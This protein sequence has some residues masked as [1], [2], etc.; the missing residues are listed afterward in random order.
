LSRIELCYISCF[1]RKFQCLQHCQ[2][3]DAGTRYRYL[4]SLLSRVE[5]VPVI[6]QIQFY[7]T[8]ETITLIKV[9]RIAGTGTCTTGST[10]TF[11]KYKLQYYGIPVYTGMVRVQVQAQVY[12]YDFHSL[13]Y[14]YSRFQHSYKYFYTVQVLLYGTSTSIRYKH[15]SSKDL[16]ILDKSRIVIRV[17]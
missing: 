7:Y 16:S 6:R 13:F 5:R 8:L 12:R 11:T 15:K 3:L 9:V 2:K 4:R 14:S 1:N 17:P 10:L